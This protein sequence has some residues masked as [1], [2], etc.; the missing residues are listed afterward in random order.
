MCLSVL[1][2]ASVFGYIC[3]ECI[4][5]TVDTGHQLL[6]LASLALLALDVGVLLHLAGH[7]TLRLLGGTA[8]QIL[9]LA[10][11]FLHLHDLDRQEGR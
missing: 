9:H 6:S 11:Q 7:Q 4:Q 1:M 5:Q 2:Y 10:V 3:L 8:H